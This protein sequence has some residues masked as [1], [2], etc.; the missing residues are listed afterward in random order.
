MKLEL[1]RQAREDLVHWAHS[2]KKTALKIAD[3]LEEISQTPYTGKG[4]PE[5]LRH[6]LSDYWSR[7]INTK[8]RI[9]YLVDE[10]TST[11]YIAS[12]RNHYS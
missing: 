5:P 11:I 10:T 9:V 7:R 8:D 6:Q 1:S 2:D 3:L 12:L 4:K